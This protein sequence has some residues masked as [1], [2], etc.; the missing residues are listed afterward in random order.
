MAVLI[1]TWI[2][3]SAILTL[4]LMES[5]LNFYLAL[6][7]DIILRSNFHFARMRRIIS[8]KAKR[9]AIK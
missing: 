4:A 3:M 1:A 2:F 8:L 9:K 5:D 7:F 6:A